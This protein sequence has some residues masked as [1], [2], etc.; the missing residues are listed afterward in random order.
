MSTEPNTPD[1][2]RVPQRPSVSVPPRNPAPA[3]GG[4][5]SQPT[6]A[7]PVS[8]PVSTTPSVPVDTPAQVPTPIAS[9]P[10]SP[11]SPSITA[12]GR[13]VSLQPL[14]EADVLRERALAEEAIAKPVEEKPSVN[15]LEVDLP[16]IDS[17]RQAKVSV[18]LPPV[19]EETPAPKRFPWV[20][21][22]LIGL[23]LPLLFMGGI[24]GA[25]LLLVTS[26]LRL[27]VALIVF[28]G[29]PYVLMLILAVIASI[30]FSKMKVRH[31][32]FLAIGIIVFSAGAIELVG[33]ISSTPLG[34]LWGW[35]GSA[36]PMQLVRSLSLLLVPFVGLIGA[37]LLVLPTNV[38]REKLPAFV[39]VLIYITMVAAP[40]VANYIVEQNKPTLEEVM[41]QEYSLREY[42]T[43]KNDTSATS[44]E[45]WPLLPATTYPKY[46]TAEI[47]KCLEYGFVVA[48][49][50][51]CIMDCVQ[52]I[53]DACVSISFKSGKLQ[54][55]H[56][57][58][59]FKNDKCDAS[60]IG[61]VMNNVV[62]GEKLPA[63]R[64]T[65]CTALRTPNGRTV[66]SE[67]PFTYES[68]TSAYV[69][70]KSAIVEFTFRMAMKPGGAATVD[71]ATFNQARNDFLGFIDT[72]EF[73]ARN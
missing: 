36:D 68:L 11:L 20:R 26:G 55:E 64:L 16:P 9:P 27:D 72:F 52:T 10:V 53:N 23:L 40:F 38:L 57:P 12:E 17:D 48:G 65:D 54:D 29:L 21:T 19:K 18:D 69:V 13:K 43:E 59:L 46:E 3:A 61:Y 39:T 56:A 62:T 37:A 47:E 60:S 1:R 42:G 5:P 44:G 28:M 22:L 35:A 14:H 25:A 71:E 63:V 67:V 30:L 15:P 24:I 6:A 66:Y 45:D 2:S 33:T 31:P 73:V 49:V 32:F 70:E 50:K 8:S 7:A 41:R 51:D 34:L 4:I 58:Y